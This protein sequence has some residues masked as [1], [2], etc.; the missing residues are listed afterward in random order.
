M[1][2]EQGGRGNAVTAAVKPVDA[3][4]VGSGQQPMTNGMDTEMQLLQVSKLTCV[5]FTFHCL[6]KRCALFCSQHCCR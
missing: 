2:D 6:L 4:G 3:P 1:G 5:D